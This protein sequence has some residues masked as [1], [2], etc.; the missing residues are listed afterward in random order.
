M[1]VFRGT[2]AFSQFRLDKLIEIVQRHVPRVVGLASAY[3]HLVDAPDDLSPMA[4]EMVQQLLDYGPVAPPAPDSSALLFVAPRPG[5]ISP[6]SSKATDIA[7]GCGLMVIKRIERGTAFYLTAS[8]AD[9]LTGREISLAARAL[10][11]RMTQSVF[12]RL[13]D[14]AQLF[15]EARPRPLQHVDV[16]A[17][18]REALVRANDDLGLALADDEID[19]LLTAFREL[20]RN[21]TDVELMMFA[22][23]NSEHCRHKIFR[24]KFV[25]DG[26]AKDR[27]LFEMIQN[28]YAQHPEGVLSAYSDN[29]AVLTGRVANRFFP[30][31]NTGEYVPHHENS[32]IIFKVET[33]NHPTAISPYPGASTGSG[34]EIRDEGATGRGSKPKAGITGFCVS[35]L[36]IPEYLRP[37]EGNPIGKPDRIVSAL[38]IMLEGPLG[39]AAFNN[40][41]GRPAIAGTFRSFEQR[42][43]SHS[44]EEVRG[45]HKPIMLAGGVGNLRANHVHKGKIAPG[46]PLVVLGGP[47]MLIGLG[48]G[49]ASSMDQGASAADL[50]F[51]SVQRD[52]PEMQRRCQEVIDRCTALGDE[53]PI[54]SIHDV[55]AGGLSNALPELV[56]DSNLGA[57]IELRSIPNAEPGMS[58]L[59]IWCNEA[60]ERYVIALDVTKRVAFLAIADRERCPY[61]LVGEATADPRIVVVD[62]L[63]GSTPIDLPLSVLFGNPPSMTRVADRV[64]RPLQP[65]DS[66]AITLEDAIERILRMP[67]IADKTFLITIGDRSVTGLVHRDQ[68]VGPWQVPVADSA[69]TLTDYV[70]YAGEAIAL[71]ER[72]PVALISAAASAR[73]AVGEALTNIA[74]APIARITDVKLS[75]NWMAAT[76]WPG[77]D[78]ALYDAVHAIGM[79][80]CPALGL[81]IPVGKDSMSMKTVWDHGR[82]T[83]LSPLSLMITAVAPLSDVRDCLTPEL[84]TQ[85]GDTELLLLDLGQ[86][87]NRLGASSLTQAYGQL[88]HEAPDVDDPQILA[89][90]FAAIQDLRK[91]KLILAY[92]DRSDGGLLVTAIEMA[93]AGGSGITLDIVSLGSDPIAALFAEELG[94]V[95]QIR[96]TDHYRVLE[97][98]AVHTLTFDKE[99]YLVGGLR[100]DDQVFVQMSETTL[101]KSSRSQLRRLWSETTFALQSL[102]DEPKSAA[103]QYDQATDSSDPG[104]SVHVPYSLDLRVSEPW[105]STT[106]VHE[107]PKL[108]ILREQGVNGQ[109]EMAA[110]FHRA[111]FACVDVH[112]SDLTS[113]LVQLQSFRGLVAC[114]GFSYGDVLGAGLG[115]A[116]SILLS[117]RTREQFAEFFRRS[118]AFALGVC[119]GCQMLAALKDI[120]PG[121]EHFPQLLRNRSEQFEARLALVEVLPSPSILLDGMHGARLPI[122]VAHGE[123]R[124]QFDSSK[125]LARLQTSQLLCARF[126]DNR[127]HATEHYPENPNGSPLG[128]T[129]LCNPDGRITLMMPHPERVFRSVQ[130]S[131]C[132]DNWNEDSPWMRL[133]DN[134][135]KWVG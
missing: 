37:W 95:I 85:A 34:G 25:V 135:R 43:P 23:A 127:G 94:A 88:G 15:D 28:T 89:N 120:I 96:T 123:G 6:W 131:W 40:E 63:F 99:V 118:D 19:Y 44:G 26:T 32:P 36:C 21:P 49:A 121:A 46:S 130:F 57:R 69:V 7:R 54:L 111:G 117:A 39:G 9:P 109:T 78:A 81:T 87:R 83:V 86:G 114:G 64:T 122:V 65:F 112:M 73:L 72:P 2:S 101:Y 125:S 4:R 50:D 48:G 61:A 106:I 116:K 58:P 62:R 53:S 29:A 3:L 38:D 5:S 107:K 92:H 115:W 27:S 60:Q 79:E 74:S 134:A 90:F 35:N 31:P 102:R 20:G 47:A 55:G 33:H 108:A 22:Q 104:L 91:R 18:G 41:F 93:F 24:A 10:H 59:E 51:A 75:A 17:M 76:G 82:K 80:M 84:K 8:D 30:D 110:A 66:R 52:N 124:M 14:A 119:N 16:V 100:D 70:G 126:V 128:S 12:V 71:G 11:D 77:E 105:L 113:G 45:F 56:H 132:P 98:L 129:A 1:L 13:D 133:F 103:Q 97:L 67:S 68:M 42:V